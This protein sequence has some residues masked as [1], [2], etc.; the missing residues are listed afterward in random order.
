MARASRYTDEL[1]SEY[2]RKGY[3]TDKIL[4]DFWDYNALH[5]PDKEAVVDS[6]SRFTWSQANQWINR[7]AL[8]LISL[9]LNR[10]DM[11]A[12]Q[13]PNCVELLLLRVACEK[14]GLLCLPILP[15]YRQGDL[16]RIIRLTEPKAFVI[17]WNFKKFDFYQMLKELK[18]TLGLPQ[19]IIVT[20]EEVPE[21]AI[22][23]SQLA[24]SP[25]ENK[26]PVNYLNVTKIKSNEFSLVNMTS[27]STGEP[28]FVEQPICSRLYVGKNFGPMQGDII[29][30]L[31]PAPGG[32]NL[33]A[34]FGAPQIVSKVVMLESFEPEMALQLMEREKVTY[35]SIVPAQLSM[36]AN[37]PNVEKYKL[38]LR[39]ILS[40]GAPLPY[41]VGLLGEEKLRA[42]VCQLYGS[43]DSGG[44]ATTKPEDSQSVRLLTV[45]KPY[46]GN[47]VRLIDDEGKDVTHTGI[48][49][50][51]SR[52]PFAVSGYFKDS[53]TTN[54]LWDKDGYFRLGDLGKF[55]EM[56]NLVL[57]GRKK[58][59]IIRGGQNI[60]PAEVENYL[61]SNPRIASAAVVSMPDPVMGEKACAYLVL[62][63]GQKMD[64]EEMVSF[65]KSKKIAAYKLPERLEVVDHFPMLAAGQ[66]ID[67]RTLQ[68]D[69]L[70]KLRSEGKV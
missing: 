10:D 8:G 11:V 33:G 61:L 49:E 53:E 6:R 55:D 39:V 32:P 51:I 66:K 45:G 27:G 43:M 63:R 3:W 50:V 17:P 34:Y 40:T 44:V 9:G 2:T 12:L 58:D 37:L 70:E 41:A 28:K 35:I 67:K 13:L 7:A 46:A 22:S 31:S 15:T 4:S 38:N 68:K 24:R 20:G 5:Y 64:F 14:A 52:G 23:L 57:V 21:Q 18:K 60:F 65:L 47:E 19:H 42:P 26:V 69:L 59:L 25:I 16:E 48:G 62:K 36:M 29:A 54:K 1:I 56:G 30:M